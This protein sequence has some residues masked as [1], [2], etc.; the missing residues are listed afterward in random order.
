MLA[1]SSW[2]AK[3]G[4]S[5]CQH[6]PSRLGSQAVV[7]SLRCTATDLL[8]GRHYCEEGDS[9]KGGGGGGGDCECR[10]AHR[11]RLADRQALVH[12]QSALP[13]EG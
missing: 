9:E 2:H 1:T 11:D 3:T 8:M 4:V 13:D 12:V 6:S 7:I 10:V 5:I